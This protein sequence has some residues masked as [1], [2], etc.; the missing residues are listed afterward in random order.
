MQTCNYF[1]CRAL[2]PNSG[3]YAECHCCPQWDG[4]LSVNFT[5]WHG[6]MCKTSQQV[7]LKSCKV[8]ECIGSKTGKVGHAA[9]T[10]LKMF[11]VGVTPYSCPNDLTPVPQSKL[12][13]T[14]PA[15][16]SP[17]GIIQSSIT[18]QSETSHIHSVVPTAS[19][20]QHPEWNIFTFGE[21]DTVK[22][23]HRLPNRQRTAKWPS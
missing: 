20:L 15:A 7:K 5:R 23:T 4:T 18:S 17:L 19:S 22:Y 8:S 16:M 11:V 9:T 14:G 12:Q 21:T 10:C 1:L 2:T 13:L 6:N 3:I